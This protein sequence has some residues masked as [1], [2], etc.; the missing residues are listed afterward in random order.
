MSSGTKNLH[1]DIRVMCQ[2]HI[3][4]SHNVGTAFLYLPITAK[5]LCLSHSAYI[6]LSRNTHYC[7]RE[8][9]LSLYLPLAATGLSPEQH[10]KETTMNK[11]LLLDE[12]FQDHS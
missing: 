4:H 9:F 12:Y 11:F 10:Y 8:Q 2:K 3:L 6:V 5:V 7:Y 1:C